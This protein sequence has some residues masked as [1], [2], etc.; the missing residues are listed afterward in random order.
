MNLTITPDL[1]REL[2]GHPGDAHQVGIVLRAGGWDVDSGVRDGHPL[3]ALTG[4]AI[5]AWLGSD[6]PGDLDDEAIAALTWPDAYDRT[7]YTIRDEDGDAVDPDAG[8]IQVVTHRWAGTPDLGEDEPA[9][10]ADAWAFDLDKATLV[11]T[12]ENRGHVATELWVTAGGRYVQRTRSEWAGGSEHWTEMGADRAVRLGYDADDDRVTG[13]ATVLIQAARHARAIVDIL[14]PEATGGA[15]TDR[16]A[17][18]LVGAIRAAGDLL[19]NVVSSDLRERRADAAR[20]VV[21]AFGGHQQN[22]ADHIARVTG[23][24]MSKQT[25]SGLLR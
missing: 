1:V 20:L 23:K 13:N 17:A 10:W 9:A 16:E 8:D 19:R 11:I 21:A 7:D 3:V 15:G 12:E 2:A 4:D 6:D 14:T 25:L 24:P 18:E 5:V 22:A